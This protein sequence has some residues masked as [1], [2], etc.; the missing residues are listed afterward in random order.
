[1]L[2]KRWYLPSLKDAA[3]LKDTHLIFLVFHTLFCLQIWLARWMSGHGLQEKNY[4]QMY[5]R[6]EKLTERPPA[7]KI[8]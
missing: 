6:L 4:R 7:F 2:G 5:G 1:M 3:W 8:G